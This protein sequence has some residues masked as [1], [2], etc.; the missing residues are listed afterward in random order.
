VWKALLSIAMLAVSLPAQ[1]SSSV[2]VQV[3][4]T[5]REVQCTPEQR[6]RVRACAQGSQSVALAPL[7]KVS[8]LESRPHAPPAFRIEVDPARQVLIRTILY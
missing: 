7:K 3:S 1:A 2:T 6:M 8:A 4:A 5:I